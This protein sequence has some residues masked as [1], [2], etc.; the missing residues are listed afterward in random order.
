VGSAAAAIGRRLG[1]RLLGTVRRAA[2][3]LAAS[4]LVDEVLNLEAK[5]L[6]EA[7]LGATGGRGADVILDVVGGSLF[8]PCMRSLA[9]RGRHVVIAGRTQVS[10]DLGDFYHREGR[11]FGVDTLKLSLAESAAIL[12]HLAPGFEDGSY[13]PPVEQRWPLA[14]APAAYARIHEGTAAGKIVLIP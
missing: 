10:F 5:P 13:G 14:D 2:E 1:A 6:A 11:L 7:V 4:G 3:I 12:R 8:E 9:H